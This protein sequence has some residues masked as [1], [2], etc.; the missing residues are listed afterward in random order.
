MMASRG[1]GV[2]ASSKR[3]K[4]TVKKRDGNEPVKLYKKGG[5][6]RRFSEGGE[7]GEKDMSRDVEERQKVRRGDS[8]DRRPSGFRFT[9]EGGRDKFVTAGGGRLS[10]DIPAGRDA[11]ISPYVE[12]FVAKPKDREL[13]GRITGAGVMYNK[14]FKSGG[15]T[16]KSKVNKAGNY[17]KPGMRESLFKSIKSQAVQGTKAGQWSARKAQL[18]AKKY[19]AK[20][21]GYRD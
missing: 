4:K 16:T 21:G 5:K 12:G 19:K 13:M 20:G 15:S 3:P 11:T 1:M 2:I 9:G 10:Y 8:S 7:A 14:Q 18:L 6:V 17:T